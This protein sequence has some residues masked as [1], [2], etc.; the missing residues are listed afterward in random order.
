MGGFAE[1]GVEGSC[2]IFL[3]FLSSELVLKIFMVD[4]EVLARAFGEYESGFVCIFEQAE[5]KL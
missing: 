2:L 1:W 4:S 5:T 3:L